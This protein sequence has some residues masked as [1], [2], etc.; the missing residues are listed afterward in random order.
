LLAKADL[1]LPALNR[2]EA[3]ARFHILEKGRPAEWY[4]FN[5]S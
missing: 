5:Q 4:H 2:G 1:L 3:A